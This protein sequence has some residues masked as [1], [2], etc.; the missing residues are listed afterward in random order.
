MTLARRAPRVSVALARDEG[1]SRRRAPERAPARRGARAR[2]KE[3]S[4]DF[5][6]DVVG[7]IFGADAL[8]DPE[9]FGLKRMNKDEW[10]DQWPAETTA[11]AAV[12]ASDEGEVREI[13]PALKQ[14][15]LEKLAL[16]CAYDAGTHGWSARAFHTQLD[17]QGA[18]VLVGKTADGE[19]FGGYNPIGWLGYGEARDAISAFLYVLDRKTGKAV[20]LPKTGGSGMAII[21]EDG[22]GPQWGP[23]GLKISLEGRSARSRLGT[24]YETMPDGGD[25]M[26]ANT[27]R[28]SPVELT[29]LRVY[30][31]LEDTEIAKN[32]QPNA[33]QWQ[34]G[35]LE[36]I[37]SNDDDPN[38]MDGFFGKL[39]GKKK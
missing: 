9:P 21:D 1:R 5:I 17:G 4:G 22:K 12:L 24:Y 10:P 35:E 6:T 15:Q 14:T 20:K 37:R 33:L 19:T 34:K 16:G 2:A 3:S 28:G 18:A 29:E 8:A 26:F 25:C 11:S 32:Y 13:R 38:H 30:V 23:D 27:K 7:K 36:E 31:S 39:F